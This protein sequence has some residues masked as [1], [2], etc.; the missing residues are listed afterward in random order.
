M[1]RD[2]GSENRYGRVLAPLA[3]ADEVEMLLGSGAEEL[4]CGLSPA[5]WTERFGAT[6]WLNRRNPGRGNL[7]DPEELQAVVERAHAANVPVYVTLNA[8]G[9][10]GEQ[11]ELVLEIAR[12]AEARHIDALIVSDLGLLLALREA[13]VQTAVHLSSLATTLNAEAVRFFA[14]LGVTRIVLPR[15]LSLQGIER[16]IAKAGHAVEYESFIL[17]EGCVYEEGYC[18]TAHGAGGAFCA[19]PWEPRFYRTGGRAHL[20][21]AEKQALDENDGWYRRWKWVQQD[22]AGLLNPNGLPS[23]PCGLCG[24]GRLMRAGVRSLKIVGRELHPVKKLASV[25]LVRAMVDRVRAGG[26]DDEVAS[27]AVAYR[28]TPEACLGGYVCYYRDRPMAPRLAEVA[29]GGR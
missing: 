26:R 16:L 21:P 4:Y 3:S 2:P 10:S 20:S 12:L 27:A 19:I 18:F 8:H 13:G 17:N 23:G 25:Q 5:A 22:C 7:D 11:M 15:S 29:A 9:Y 24:I 28:G 1:T 6:A 14:D